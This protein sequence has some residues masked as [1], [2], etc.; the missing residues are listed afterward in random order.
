MVRPRVLETTVLGAAYLAGL[1][2][3][4]WKDAPEI[5]KYWKADRKFTP[6]M[7]PAVRKQLRAGWAKALTRSMNW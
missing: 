7:K 5:A 4:Y 6:A 1:A 3:G 2:V